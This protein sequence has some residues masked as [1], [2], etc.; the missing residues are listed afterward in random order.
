MLGEKPVLI[1]IIC[2]F[3]IICSPVSS[4]GI[5][6]T[7]NHTFDNLQEL[8]ADIPDESTYLTDYQ[9]GINK[10]LTDI[11]SSLTLGK[12]A[13][14][15]SNASEAER[16]F[17]FVIQKS[18]SSVPAWKGLFV[19]LVLQE[20]YDELF[21][22]TQER[23][24]LSPYDDWVWI[25]RGRVEQE[26]NKIPESLQSFNKALALNSKNVF[27]HYYSAWSHQG[28]KQNQNA[29]KAFEKVK[30]LSPQYGGV[31]GNIGFLYLGMNEYE[32]ALPYL[33]NALVW[34]PDWA[35]ARRSKA[36]ILYHLGEKEEALAAFDEAISLNP[37]YSNT[38]LSKAEA[39]RDMKRYT[40]ALVPVETGLSFEKNNTDLL[41]MKGDILMDLNRF[42][43][44]HGIFENVTTIYEMDPDRKNN[45][46]NGLYSWWARGYSKEQLGETVE[47]KSTYSRALTELEPYMN[48]QSSGDQWHLKS[49][50]LTGLGEYLQA[51]VAEK[52]AQEL[53]Y[54][55][56]YYL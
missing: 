29:I 7:G 25:E 20:K 4:A 9:Q 39:L 23:I 19:S 12:T 24:N 2:F 6:F 48:S 34:Y 18:P 30:V 33:E 28:L 32:K 13:L 42:D 3:L 46:F 15:A 52:K 53:G 51:E 38:Y 16:Q 56:Q 10:T 47:A 17:S 50:I 21:N 5:P 54:N 27:A 8:I 43:E 14:K 26:K 36:M 31:D 44:A 35:E 49:K 1:F 41:M 11:S 40:E 55:E 45:V 37:E 22:K